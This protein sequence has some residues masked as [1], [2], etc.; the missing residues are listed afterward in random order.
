MD[1]DSNRF[2]EREKDVV[3]L[4]L[5]GKSN[6]QVALELGISN[7]T[8]EFHLSN[9]YAKLEVTSRT[10]A[11]LKLAENPLWESTGDDENRVQVK[12]T[13]EANSDSSENGVKPISRRIPMRNLF[14]FIGGVM[15]TTLL[16]IALVLANPPAENTEVVPTQPLQ[17]LASQITP[18]S[19]AVEETEVRELVKDFGKKLQIV[20][21]QAPDAAQEIQDQY[22]GFVEPAL[23]EI[24]MNN[25]MDAPGRS[26]SSPWP[27]RI[28][29]ITLTK[30]DSDRYVITGSVI[31]VTSLEVAN[32]GI[33]AKIP[34]RIVVQNDQGHWRISEYGEER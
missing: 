27:D 3:N 26:V 19:D 11:V 1:I 8:V 18:K 23:L 16:V 29:I 20:S 22:S 2:S 33:A 9:I 24:W 12:S 17:T 21:L 28:E 7:R 13:V 30:E 6:K 34:V 5:Q 14:Y 15:L 4:L 32:G 10:E 31:E 25:V